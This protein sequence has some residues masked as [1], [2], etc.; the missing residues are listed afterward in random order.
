MGKLSEV[1]LVLVFAEPGDPRQGEVHSDIDTATEFAL[2]S[3]ES[4]VSPFHQNVRRILDLCFPGLSFREQM[5]YAWLTESVLCSAPSSTAPVRRSIADKCVHSYLLP[6]LALFPKAKVAA[7]GS[8]AQTRLTA[9]GINF[10][11]AFA[12]APP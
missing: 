2:S 10:I 12:A 4:G 5:R 1:R 3:F 7:L 6:Q 9:A 8:K 11:P